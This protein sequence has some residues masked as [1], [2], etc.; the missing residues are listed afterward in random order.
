MHLSPYGIRNRKIFQNFGFGQKTL[1]RFWRTN[2]LYKRF[3]QALYTTVW[4]QNL[5][6]YFDRGYGKND[7]KKRAVFRPQKG[8]KNR[9]KTH[10]PY[11]YINP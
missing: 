6:R 1:A 11:G 10:T 7:H 9:S 5:S 8:T 4:V 2:V 3:I